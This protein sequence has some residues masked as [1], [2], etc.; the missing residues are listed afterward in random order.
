MNSL[1]QFMNTWTGRIA[2]IVLGFV[3]IYVGL[4]FMGGGILGYVVALVGV[5]P[6]VMAVWGHCLPE[7]IV[8]QG[9]HI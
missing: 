4:V 8:S 5:V 2:R 3:L 9:K 6:I 1:I 7:F